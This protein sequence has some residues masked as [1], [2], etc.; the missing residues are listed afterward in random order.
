[1]RHFCA[2]ATRPAGRRSFLLGTAG[3]LAAG[4]TAYLG[5][6]GSSAADSGTRPL[7]DHLPV[8]LPA[9]KPIAG[10]FDI[11][12]LI[13]EFIPGPEEITLPF[14]LIPLQGLNVEPSTLTDF[15][16]VTALAYHVGTVTGSDGLTYNL[17]TDVRVFQGQYVGEDGTQHAGIFGEM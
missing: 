6:P 5:R 13:H 15:T 12:P 4:L 11:P 7:P 2:H 1:M 10:G 17:E 9:P 16:G 14:T 3:A 8:P